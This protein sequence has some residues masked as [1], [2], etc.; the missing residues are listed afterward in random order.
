M[1][2]LKELLAAKG[3][4]VQQAAE[5]LGD[6][7]ARL[8]RVLKGQESLGKTASLAVLAV[9]NDLPPICDKD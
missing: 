5:A 8:E 4:N 1:D 9:L 6:D 3:W 2:E 7:E